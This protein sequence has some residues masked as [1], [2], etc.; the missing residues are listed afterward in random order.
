MN[1]IIK[2]KKNTVNKTIPCSKSVANRIIIISKIYNISI[3]IRNFLISEDIKIMLNFIKTLGSIIYRKGKEV[4]IYNIVSKKK[5]NFYVKNAGTVIRNII[6]YLCFSNFK[7]KLDG[8]KNMRRRSLEDLCNSLKEIGFNV[9]F[10]KK[11]N[12]LPLKTSNINSYNHKKKLVIDCKKSSQYATSLLINLP[13]LIKKNLFLL[14]KNINSSYSYI[15][16][17]IK[18]LRKFNISLIKIKYNYFIIKPFI[19]ENYRLKK[20][21]IEKDFT[22]ISYIFFFLITNNINNILLKTKK[23]SKQGDKKLLNIFNNFLFK[24][25][26]IN[27]KIVIYKNIL[28]KKIRNIV[29]NCKNIP[30]SGMGFL[31]LFKIT[32]R[33]K[34]FNIKSL[35]YKETNRI[36]AISKEMR[37]IGFLTKEGKNWL[38][39]KKNKIRN[40]KIRSYNDHRIAM[41]FYIFSFSLKYKLIINNPNC[42]KKTFY[43]FFKYFL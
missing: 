33:L 28:S 14:I 5:N 18:I 34:L 23:K 6:S 1:K 11:K 38:I 26:I 39:I 43:N 20:I 3:R 24:N 40:T 10:L 36:Y 13:F 32:K 9:F 30:D 31:C 37:K 35:N 29:I 25:F 17:T 19:R 8:N 41:V 7:L 16:L 42:V 4:K 15:N 2:L 21:I 27:K 22:S 12:F